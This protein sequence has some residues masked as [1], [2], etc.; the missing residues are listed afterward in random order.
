MLVGVSRTQL[1]GIAHQLPLVGCGQW[2]PRELL[3]PLEPIPGHAFPITQGG[4]NGGHAGIIFVGS[5]FWGQLGREDLAAGMAAQLHAQDGFDLVQFGH[6]I[7]FIQL[8]DFRVRL[9][10]LTLTP[11]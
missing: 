11:E 4:D 2:N 6:E 1:R 5:R 9:H 3:D 8:D 10:V 7:R